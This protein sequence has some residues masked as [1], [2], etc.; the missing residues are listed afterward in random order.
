MSS[1]HSVVTFCLILCLLAALALTGQAQVSSPAKEPATQKTRPGISAAGPGQWTATLAGQKNE[2]PGPFAIPAGIRGRTEFLHL[3]VG[4]ITISWKNLDSGKSGTALSG[5]DGSYAIAPLGSGR[6]SLEATGQWQGKTVSGETLL[7]LKAGDK[8]RRDIQLDGEIGSEN[9]VN[10]GFEASTGGVPDNWNFSYD[11]WKYAASFSSDANNPFNG[12]A[13][14]RVSLTR[15]GSPPWYTW[16]VSLHQSPV[17]VTA[18]TDYILSFAARVDTPRRVSVNVIENGG[19]WQWY[20]GGEI[21]IGTDWKH[22]SILFT[23]LG[24]NPAAIFRFDLGD[25]AGSWTV[26]TLWFDDVS[27][28]AF[29][30][31]VPAA[32]VMVDQAGYRPGDTKI[33]RIAGPAQAFDVI[34]VQT[35]L[36]VFSGI[37]GLLVAGD[38]A[39]GEDV[40]GADFTALTAPG[41]Y[42]VVVAGVGAS[43]SFR[44]A[45]KVYATHMIDALKALYFQRCGVALDPYCCA[46]S[47]WAHPAC[48]TALA[49]FHSS[50]GYTGTRDVTGGWH[51][52]GD[53]GRYVVPGAVAVGFLL[54]AFEQYPSLFDDRSLDIPESHN[55]VPDI[56]DET[57]RELEWL[58]KMQESQSGGVFH[59]VTTLYPPTTPRPED[60]ASPMYIFGFSS[61][62][63]A[64]FAAVTAQ[65]ARLFA[66]YDSAFATTCRSAA[67]AAWGF[68]KT[69]PGIYPA[70]SGFQN[71]PG[72]NSGEYGDGY[73]SDERLWAAVELFLTTGDTE[74]GNYINQNYH[75]WYGA[76]Y[77]KW[78][79]WQTVGNLALN[80]YA[81]FGPAGAVRDAIRIDQENLGLIHAAGSQ[82]SGYGVSLETGDYYWGSNMLALD[83]GSTLMETFSRTGNTLFRDTA[84]AQLHYILGVNTNSTSYLSG[85]GSRFPMTQ[86]DLHSFSDC[87]TACVPGFV[88]GGPDRYRSDSVLQYFFPSGTPAAACFI[89]RANSYASN[90]I[91]IYWNTPL[92][93]LLAQILGD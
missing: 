69:N 22:Y 4:G 8:K 63:T 71:P 49:E 48:H 67:V 92:V 78:G 14:A 68:L 6:Y 56:L 80:Q 29:P 82:A 55:G 16:E 5:S 33:A 70:P 23:C 11:T 40:Y 39:S 77:S 51:D 28:Q 54:R 74:Y 9:I 34:D 32:P 25:E 90:E 72:V 13:S 43:N 73:D 21:D 81:R 45:D 30:L 91:T 42:S 17:A 38:A 15:I 84:L 7:R 87:V 19:S 60:D 61:A 36:P 44:I 10:G 50:S 24:N 64:D 47:G 31:R 57:R 37:C 53:Y 79:G 62:A 27:L 93:M 65:A 18:G 52:A 41:D 1:S 35:A 3:P 20:G 26:S 66:S 83:A 89:D 85:C 2:G 46:E 12:A 76:T 75:V 88:S 59:K 58:L 86:H